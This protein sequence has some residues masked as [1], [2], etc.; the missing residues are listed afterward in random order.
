MGT[1]H[2]DK[3]SGINGL[4]V[5]KKDSEV[6]VASLTGQLYQ[7]GTALTPSAAELNTLTGVTAS[8]AE[9]NLIDGSVAGT[10][11]A[12]KAVVLGSSKEIATITTATITTVNAVNIDAGASG[13]AGSIDIFPAT[14]SKGKLA[15]TCANQTG[16]TAVNVT[17]A[18]MAAARTLTIPDPGAAASFVMTEGAQTLNGVKT[19]GAIPVLP[20]TGITFGAT[21]ISETEAAFVDGVTAGTVTASKAIVV[22]ANK[23]ADVLTIG[24]LSLGAGAGT[25]IVPTAAQINLLVQGVA[26]GY[27]VAMG[28]TSVTGS[29]TVATGL[30]TVVASACSLAEDATLDAL[31]ATSA[32]SG[33]AGSI[34]MKVWKPT[35]TGDVTPIA[36]TVAKKVDWIA[37]GT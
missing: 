21:T 24:T 3:V 36:A 1:T 37:I 10:A 17:T 32:L 25:S 16:D 34:L 8:A 4:Y 31:W 23:R 14:A 7:S 2:F 12:G 11:V 9:L 26:A 28:E 6:T 13:S 5:G 15:I 20:A 29:A 18:A 30:A 35:A 33:T 27:K 22:D 19:F